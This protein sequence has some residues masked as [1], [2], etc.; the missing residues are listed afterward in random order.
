MTDTD[1]PGFED[2]YKEMVA[3]LGAPS[4]KFGTRG[5]WLALKSCEFCDVRGAAD[6]YL[7]HGS[8]NEQW[9]MPRAPQWVAKARELAMLRQREREQRTKSCSLCHG[10]GVMPVQQ[11]GVVRYARCGCRGGPLP[12]KPKKA[13]AQ[14]RGWTSPA[15][16]YQRWDTDKGG[17]A[18]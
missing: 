14:D 2:C 3:A 8:G 12:A 17:D 4:D 10:D 15:E 5:Y 1:K 9:P 16:A 6:W 13:H 11:D 7:E 18:A